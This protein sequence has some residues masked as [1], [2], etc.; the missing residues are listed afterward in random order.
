MDWAFAPN[1]KFGTAKLVSKHGKFF[2]HV[3]VTVEVPNSPVPTNITNVVGIDRG[4]RF[5]ASTYDSQG[6]TFLYSGTD[7]KR[8]RA[9]YKE[10]RSQLQMRQ[11]PSARRRLKAIGSRENRWI[12][13]VNH[14]LS[15]ALV[16]SQPKGTLFCIEDLTNIREATERVRVK[17]RY[18]SVSWAYYDFETK[19]MYKAEH[20]GDAVIK[21]D[22]R[23]TSQ[24]CPKC[25]HVEKA[26]R[27]HV[28]HTFKCCNCGY[29]SNDD[30]IAAMNLHRMGIEYLMQ[31]QTSVT[32]D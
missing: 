2:L 11:A 27:N 32:E 24:T 1:T 16:E 23:Y 9:H 28:K 10:I 6:K 25:G 14:C 22:P 4:I 18:V 3:P 17:D 20:K 26:N 12:N 31:T 30:R 19:L 7:I 15:K 5:L 13:D 29:T 8:R 21:V